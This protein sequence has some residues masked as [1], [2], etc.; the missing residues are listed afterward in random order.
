MLRL[1]PEALARQRRLNRLH[2]ASLVC[3]LVLLAGATGLVVAG[4]EGLVIA[5]IAALLFFLL[6]PVVPGDP[7]F[8]RAFG[9]IRLAPRRRQSCLKPRR[10]WRAGL[11]S[12]RCLH[13]TWFPPVRCRRWPREPAKSPPLR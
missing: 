6:D 7:L 3:G 4:L 5:A 2:S 11:I 12:R 10:S 1:N 8:R 13:C 9:A